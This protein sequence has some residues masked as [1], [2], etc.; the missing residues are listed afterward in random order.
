[1]PPSDF[2]MDAGDS[3]SSSNG[4]KFSSSISDVSGSD[5]VARHGKYGNDPGWYSPTAAGGG[6]C[7]L[8]TLFGYNYYSAGPCK[9]GYAH[10]L[11]WSTF[12]GPNIALK[13]IDLKIRP[14]DYDSSDRFELGGDLE[15][16][17]DRSLTAEYETSY[18]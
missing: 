13:K 18:E 2:A 8:A 6:K 3:L 7:T 16:F 1:M 12:R 15:D 14:K 9:D 10:C 17:L 4:S 5:C 11:S